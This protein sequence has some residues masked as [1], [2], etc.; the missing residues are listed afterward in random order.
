MKARLFATAAAAIRSLKNPAHRATISNYYIVERA[1]GFDVRTKG[2]L[3]P[4]DKVV[5]DGATL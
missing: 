3:Q 5:V 1:N 4:G 2:H